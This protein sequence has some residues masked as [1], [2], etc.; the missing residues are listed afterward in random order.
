VLES[1]AFL[2]SAVSKIKFHETASGKK[3]IIDSDSVDAQFSSDKILLQ[4]VL[5]NIL[6]NALEATARGGIVTIG[7]ALSE[8]G[9]KFL[10]H[11][12]G[13]IPRD[14]QLQIFQRSYSTK[15]SGRG[16]GTYSIKLLTEKY[17]GGKVGFTTDEKEGTVF[18]AELPG[19]KRD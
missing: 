14:V 5:I 6:K 18:C 7:C 3:I 12:D 10:V 11:N 17:L 13:F 8:N 15:G 16:M 4:R 9:I 2:F 1:K 19:I